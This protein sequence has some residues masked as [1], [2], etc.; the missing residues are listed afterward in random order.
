MNWEK[1]SSIKH[2]LD[3]RR[4][5]RLMEYWGLRITIFSLG[6]AVGFIAHAWFISLTIR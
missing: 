5:E 3:E 1:Q 6:L 2:I 4:H